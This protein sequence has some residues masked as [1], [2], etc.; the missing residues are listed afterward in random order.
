MLSIKIVKAKEVIYHGTQTIFINHS[1]KNLVLIISWCGNF[2]GG[3][4]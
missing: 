4:G 2:K 3:S 1:N